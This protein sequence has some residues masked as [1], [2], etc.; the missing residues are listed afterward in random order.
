[1]VLKG[2]LESPVTNSIVILLLQLTL[3]RLSELVNNLL[4]HRP[5]SI[6]LA[7]TLYARGCSCRRAIAF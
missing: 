4:S 6:S 7:L 1:M 5:A 3:Q 2:A